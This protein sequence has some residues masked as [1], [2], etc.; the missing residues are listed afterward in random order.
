[1]SRKARR[2]T[3]YVSIVGMTAILV[4]FATLPFGGPGQVA[5]AA[6]SF[7]FG[8]RVL[9]V[10]QCETPIGAYLIT[11]GAPI[12]G[13]YIVYT[14]I[15]SRCFAFGCPSLAGWA[16]GGA[17]NY[18]VCDTTI[19]KGIK[20]IRA[21]VIGNNPGVGSSLVAK[22]KLLN[23]NATT[24][25]T[26]T[27]STGQC[28]SGIPFKPGVG[29]QLKPDIKLSLEKYC[30]A[31]TAV[32]WQ[33]TEGCPA[34]ITH[35]N[36]CHSQCTCVDIGF[37]SRQYTPEKIKAAL[38]AGNNVGAN[39]VFETND[40]PLYRSLLNAGLHTSQVKYYPQV[41]GSHFS[42]YCPTCKP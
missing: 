33:V 34:A 17:S 29:T 31:A 41:T 5:N 21:R 30:D 35:A 13:Q 10:E 26:S 20:N 40:Y 14:P 22:D 15:G 23:N 2:Y 19:G 39:L 7:P 36:V 1:M 12:G 38:D 4:A 27:P 18:G 6:L 28:K 25:A 16:L 8:G 9:S 32:D 24:T 42:Y 37:Q 3:G 11:L